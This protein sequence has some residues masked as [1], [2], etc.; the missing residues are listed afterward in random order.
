LILDE[1]NNFF[2]LGFYADLFF[3]K[4]VEFG[5][6]LG[7]FDA[8]FIEVTD[9]SIGVFIPDVEKGDT[10]ISTKVFIGFLIKID[11]L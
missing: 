1:F 4:S 5:L 9:T 11:N 10:N 3:A 7:Y 8:E 6:L 2:L